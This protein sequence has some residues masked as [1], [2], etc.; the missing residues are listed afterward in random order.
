MLISALPACLQPELYIAARR[1]RTI[2]QTADNNPYRDDRDAHGEAFSWC[3][4]K[5]GKKLRSTSVRLLLQCRIGSSNAVRFAVRLFTCATVQHGLV[6]A[7][8]CRQRAAAAAAA[9][10]ADATLPA[11][12]R[13][14]WRADARLILTAPA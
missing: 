4:A 3:N 6:A 14:V 8:L 11:L 13:R 7:H 9:A 1:S 2:R 5:H 12:Q 10:D